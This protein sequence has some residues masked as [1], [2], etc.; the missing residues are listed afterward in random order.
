[1]AE[2]VNV[3]KPFL[4]KLKECHWK[5]IDQGKGIP[6][7]PC[8]SM[9]SSF[10]EVALKKEFIKNVGAINPW[11]TID[12]LEWCYDRI[13]YGHGN[14]NL[15]EINKR[16]FTYLRKGIQVD[17]NK[18]T[19]EL[20]PTIKLIDFGRRDENGEWTSKNSFVAINQFKVNT[21]GMAKSCIIPDIVCF[22]NGL[23]WVIIECK[24]FDV[25]EPLSDAYEQIRRYSNQRKDDD[26]FASDEGKEQ[27]FYTNLFNV[28]TFGT[29]ARFGSIS[30]EFDYY[31]NWADIFP[32]IYKTPELGKMIETKEDIAN[33]VK[34]GAIRQEVIIGGMFNH[35]ILIDVLRN[36]T[37][38]MN[39]GGKEAKVICRYQQYRAVGKMIDRLRKGS[40]W[41]ERSGVIWHTQGSGKSLTMVFLVKKMRSEFDLKDF[42]ILMVVDRLDLESQLSETANLTDEKVNQVSD[43]RYLVTLKT[44][45]PNLNLVMIHKFA[46]NYDEAQDVLFKKGIVPK[47]E[48]LGELNSSEKILIL[49]DE[50]HRSQNGDMNNNLFMAFPNATRFG[51]TGTPL[52]T[53]RHKITT[54]ER[55]CDAPGKF[56]DTYKMND[57]VRDRAT[58]DVK[59]IGMS[60]SDEI[61]DKEAFDYEYE[62]TFKQHAEKER[63][64]IQKRYGD[65][66]AYLESEDRV[67]EIANKMMEHYVSDILPNGFKAMVVVSSI[68]AAVRYKIYIEKELIPQCIAKEEQK[69]EGERDEDLLA[70][71]KILKV[72][73][74]VS[75][76]GN[77]EP[78]YITSAR[79]EGASKAVTAAFKKD[80]NSE[81]ESTGIGILCVCDRLL[82]GFDAPIAQVLYMDK[83]LRE[84]DLLQAIARVNRTKKGKTH[85]LVVDYFG[86][87]KNLT[88]A[89]GIYTDVEKKEAKKDLLEFGEY[90]KDIQKEIP[91]LEIRYNK[92]VQLFEDHSIINIQ[93]FLNQKIKDTKEDMAVVEKVI[94]IAADMKFRAEFDTYIKNYFDRLDLLFN[95]IE[96]QKNHWIKAKRL[97]YLL[98]RIRIHYKDETLDLKWASPKVRKLIDKYIR[99]LNIE[100]RVS[101]V[102]I[103]SADFPKEISKYTKSKSQASAMEHAIRY[104][105]K[106]NLENKDP[107][108]YS[109]F[110][111]KLECIIKRYQGNWDQ[112]LVEFKELQK[113]I[114]VGRKEDIRFK[115]IQMPFY[116]SL[117]MTLSCELSEDVDV[118]LVQTTKAICRDIAND[119][120]IAYFWNKPDEIEALRGKLVGHLRFS[121]ISELKRNYLEISDK[122]MMLAKYNYSEVLKHKDE[123]AQ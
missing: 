61:T 105:I 69:P 31:Y 24:D 95:E 19:D 73:A 39:A 54:A 101:E 2:Y 41:R 46:D 117:K 100:E 97:G 8:K 17:K 33:N 1:M 63:Q 30:A 121:D 50:A 116:E 56:I 14:E 38:Y 99:N 12:Q 26:Y 113:D 90:F 29:E 37:I 66:I 78:G 67:K 82:T 114:A 72:R 76:L 3:E 43:K 65:M 42:K 120:S 21:V 58:V 57:A 98:T 111:D 11:A 89:L 32:E 40:D 20:N 68:R 71:L 122:I 6:T 52:L 10:D 107:A 59:Y 53:P 5:V 25:A 106:V 55:F 7:D 48:P 91:E 74:V 16:V 36:F 51:F 79:I 77:N 81:D 85:G 75:S 45:T 96:V 18:Q 9:R 47:F 92:I 104:H 13:L 84:H 64:E 93:D 112:M 83:N 103:L 34:P 35:E 27:L 62:E 94:E 4:E 49:V 118:K 123:M 28:I 102:S 110:K 23:P 108:L 80:F 87:T 70:K 60:T 44:D 119:M 115:S 86:I 22:V 15:T 88:R 109:K